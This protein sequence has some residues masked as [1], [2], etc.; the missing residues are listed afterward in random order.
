MLCD[1]HGNVV[2]QI[3]GFEQKTLKIISSKKPQ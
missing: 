3:N 2:S 1:E